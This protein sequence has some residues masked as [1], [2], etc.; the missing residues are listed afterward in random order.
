MLGFGALGKIRVGGF[1]RG[2]GGYVEE[3]FRR[4]FYIASREPYDVS[5]S[6]GVVLLV[7][8]SLLGPL[9]LM[10]RLW[11]LPHLPVDVGEFKKGGYH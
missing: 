9:K 11:S 6:F 7:T 1:P 8:L 2:R 3:V 4:S 10:L 5:A